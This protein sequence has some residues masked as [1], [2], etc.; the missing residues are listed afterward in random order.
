MSLTL[1][2]FGQVREHSLLCFSHI[3]DNPGSQSENKTDEMFGAFARRK[4]M[5]K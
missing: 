4:S 3:D 1:M 5:G 2:L